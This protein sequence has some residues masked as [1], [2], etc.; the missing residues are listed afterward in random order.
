MK[1]YLGRGLSIPARQAQ[2]GFSLIELLIVFGVL[3]LA[4]SVAIPNF[5]NAQRVSRMSGMSREIATQLRLVR[6]EAMGQL[7]AMTLQYNDQ[8]KQLVVIRHATSCLQSPMVRPCPLLTDPNYPNNGTVIRTVPLTGGGV[9]AADIIYGRPTG[10]PAVPLAD[11][12]TLSALTSG[13]L[14]ITFQPDGSVLNSA[15]N[16]VD[17]ALYFYN[18]RAD[19]DTATAISVLGSAGRV[20]LWRYSKGTNSYVE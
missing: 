15:G 2:A 14:N 18:A 20:K 6:Q 12:T 8:N 13:V 10:V 4:L 1:T 7:C 17:G 16:P 3:A 19:K 9:P 5:V 11:K